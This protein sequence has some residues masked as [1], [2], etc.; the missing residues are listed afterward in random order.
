MP[1]TTRR[2]IIQ[3]SAVGGLA[4]ALVGG[5]G[6]EHFADLG[7]ALGGD[8]VQ[9]GLADPLGALQDGQIRFFGLALVLVGLLLLWWP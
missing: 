8:R 4:G 1:R 5:G 9:P 2:R 3:T 6:G 7:P